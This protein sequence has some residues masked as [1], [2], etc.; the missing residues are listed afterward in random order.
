MLLRVLY[1]NVFLEGSPVKIIKR[2]Y[3]YDNTPCITIDNS[4]GT[5]IIQ[6][7][8]INRDYIIPES[9]PQYDPDNPSEVISQQVLREERRISIDINVWVDTEDEREELNNQ[10][11]NLFKQVQSDYYKFCNN[12]DNGNCNYL[13]TACK[14][15]SIKNGRSAKMQCPYPNDFHYQNIFKTFDIIRS[16]FDVAPSYDLDDKTVNPQVLRSI[17]NVSFNYYDYYVIGGVISQN[18]HID[19]ELL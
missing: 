3:P 16:T 1:N 18:L 11:S 9:H 10:I 13:D 4:S 12:Y 5:S 19:E 8:I 17:T 7:N 2:D 14:V 15:L 6:K